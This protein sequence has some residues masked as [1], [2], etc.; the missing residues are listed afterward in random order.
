M[1]DSRRHRR[2]RRTMRVSFNRPATRTLASALPQARLGRRGGVFSAAVLLLLLMTLLALPGQ[3]RALDTTKWLWGVD[4][5]DADNGCA[6]GSG[7]YVIT[8][9]D[10]GANWTQRS[11]DTGND[12]YGVAFADA[13][14]GWIV[15]DGGTIRVTTNG[16]ASW[17]A[18]TSGTSQKLRAVAV[19]DTNSGWAVGEVDDGDPDTPKTGLILR[20]VNGGTTWTST[21][22][23]QQLRDVVFINATTGWAVGVGGYVLKTSDGGENWT[24]QTSGTSQT[25]YGVDFV[26][27]SK[28][29]A[30]GD[31]GTVRVTSNGGASWSGQTSGTSQSLRD[32]VFVNATT[33]WLVGNAGVVRKTTNG[34]GDWSRQSAPERVYLL[35]ADFA[36]A[37]HGCIVGQAATVITTATGSFTDLYAPTT[38]AAAFDQDAWYNSAVSVTFTALDNPGGSGV[39]TT[40]YK[41]DDG[42]WT[43]GTTASVAAPANHSNDGVHTVSYRSTDLDGN[44]EDAKSVTVRIDTQ[45][46]QGTMAINDGDATT[47]S[48]DVTVNSSVSDP[49]G[50]VEMRISTN[51]KTSWTAWAAYAASA[52]AKLAGAGGE[53]TVVVQYRDSLG[54]VAELSDT[55]TYLGP[56]APAL[57]TPSVPSS[58]GAG[59]AFTVWGTL[60]PASAATQVVKLKLYRYDAGKPVLVREYA[61]VNATVG[62]TTKYSAKITL[63]RKAQYSFKAYNVASTDWASTTTPNSAI[64][65]VKAIATLGQP[66]A[67]SVV[68]KGQR[69]TVWG[70]IKP[71]VTAGS[72][73]VKL[74]LYRYTS[75][76]WSYVKTYST[77]NANYSSYSKYSTRIAITTRGTYRFKA[78]WPESASWAAAAST[79]SSSK[80]VR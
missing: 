48:L 29:W 62:D 67:P 33:G 80:T 22:F 20:T 18:Q 53:K 6:V 19:A 39:A 47:D 40:E 58:V 42:A 11:A 27:A 50:P 26:D 61:T 76:K 21:A 3:A 13:D 14:K 54:N 34:G 28:G 10:G 72:K 15:G 79:T 49:R 57:G 36:D 73:T 16:G 44:V 77:V 12:L 35:K 31:A 25:L 43:P 63:T 71:R 9:A 2:C 55:I 41:L 51:N 7:G 74:N 78:I 52:S 59:K 60:G 64:M 68:N 45:G 17:A 32:V 4:F 70:T 23:P 65:K 30:V 56:P 66:K 24:P 38:T 75:G 37:S 5:T 46:P 8:T 69:F 1:S